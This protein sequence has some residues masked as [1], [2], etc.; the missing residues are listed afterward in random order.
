MYTDYPLKVDSTGVSVSDYIIF[1]NL[2]YKIISDLDYQHL[3]AMQTNHVAT[4]LCRDNRISY[5][6]TSISIPYPEIDS[7]FFSFFNLIKLAKDTTGLTALWAFQQEL[8][9]AFPYCVVNIVDVDNIENTNYTT[10]DGSGNFVYSKASV[11]QVTFGFYSYDKIEAFTY[12]QM[13][14]VKMERSQYMPNDT[15]LKYM[16]STFNT[17]VI[18]EL[19]E[20]RSIFRFEVT[21]TLNAVCELSDTN[22]TTINTIAYQLSGV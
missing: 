6:G 14:L 9:P 22:T 10:L 13:F 5:N 4:L 17:T 15:K 18:E 21:M 1:N 3:T 16:S 7:Q 19:Y 8:R 11:V 2:V 20:N 12:A